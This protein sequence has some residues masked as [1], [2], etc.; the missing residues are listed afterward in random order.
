MKNALSHNLDG[1]CFKSDGHLGPVVPYLPGR[2]AA[3][4]LPE[5]TRATLPQGHDQIWLGS[6][7]PIGRYVP[8]SEGDL[9]VGTC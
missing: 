7:M 1:R 5:L 6:T 9:N 3:K 8:G 4:G 2:A